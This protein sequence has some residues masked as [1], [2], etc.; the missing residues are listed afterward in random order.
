MCFSNRHDTVKCAQELVETPSD[1]VQSVWILLQWRILLKH[2]LVA[3]ILTWAS[4]GREP[5]LPQPWLQRATTTA[6]PAPRPPPSRL[7]PWRLCASRWRP[8][9]PRTCPVFRTPLRTSA[10]APA[11]VSA[12][13][14]GRVLPGV[15][16]RARGLP[17][18]W[19]EPTRRT[20]ATQSKVRHTPFT[21]RTFP[22]SQL[23]SIY[24][25]LGLWAEKLVLNWNLTI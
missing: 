14:P 5:N 19:E 21:K 10:P 17:H 4:L 3:A 24:S 8:P 18:L 2:K 9:K 12:L 23:H 22:G 15:N 16:T 6:L 13:G 1:R 11:T 25:K 20:T 7:S